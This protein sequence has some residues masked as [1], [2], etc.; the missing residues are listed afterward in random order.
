ME[1][2]WRK[3]Y[4]PDVPFE[5]DVASRSLADLFARTV[6]SQGRASR[7]WRPWCADDRSWVCHQPAND[8]VPGD[9]FSRFM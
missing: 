5:A 1:R 9:G 3:R 4:P 7:C 2:I 8:A 6:A